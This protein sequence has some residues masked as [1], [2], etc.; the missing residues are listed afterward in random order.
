MGVLSLVLE[1]GQVGVD[2][3]QPTAVQHDAPPRRL[4]GQAVNVA[5]VHDDVV[6]QRRRAGVAPRAEFH[7]AEGH[8]PRHRHDLEPDEPEMMRPG[9]PLDRAP[10]ARPHDNLRHH[11]GVGRRH[12]RARRRQAAVGGTGPHGDPPRAGLVGQRER[13]SERRPRLERDDIAR[14]RGVERGLK[15]TA[16]RHGD[17]LAGWCDERRVEEHAGRLGR[18]RLGSSDDRRGK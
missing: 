3:G 7:Q 8:R 11:G 4:P 15:I 18:Q 13:P 12:A 17:G 5:A 6:R 9:R 2:H 1:V 16:R 14:L 10:G